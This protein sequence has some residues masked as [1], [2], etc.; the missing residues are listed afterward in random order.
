MILLTQQQMLEQEFIESNLGYRQNYEGAV[1][2]IFRHPHREN[3]WF[4]MTL[5]N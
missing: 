4:A 1:L 3:K 5:Q 2:Y